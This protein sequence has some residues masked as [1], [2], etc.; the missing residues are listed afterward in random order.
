MRFRSTTL[1]PIIPHRIHKEKHTMHVY[2][3]YHTQCSFDN[4]NLYHVNTIILYVTF[5]APSL[6]LQ[7]P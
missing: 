2:T 4:D 3:L 7:V 1:H 5:L 6:K